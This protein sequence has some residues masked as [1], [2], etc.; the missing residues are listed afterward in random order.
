MTTQRAPRVSL[1]VLFRAVLFRAVLFRAVLFRAV[2][3]RAVLFLAVP[4]LA[5]P[6]PVSAQNVYVLIAPEFAF[7]TLRYSSPWQ[8]LLDHD[9]PL[10]YGGGADLGLHFQSRRSMLA[11]RLFTGLHYTVT[12][13][14]AA[15]TADLPYGEGYIVNTSFDESY[16]TITIPLRAE[17]LVQAR[18]SKVIPGF[19]V[20][21]L[22]NV[23]AS[24]RETASLV[25]GSR[26]END[27]PVRSPSFAV[28]TGAY[29]DLYVNRYV[30]LDF[31]AGY[32]AG[33]QDMLS[34]KDASMRL[35]GVVI[36]AG[37]AIRIR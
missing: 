3:F 37:V 34:D 31:R 10:S 23:S 14:S 32:A 13:V 26:S 18:N 25:D 12:K 30:A 7:N 8:G 36:G 15:V 29:L 27:I 9:R 35:N 5:T 22:V 1:T 17:I 16:Q 11:F 4:F 6:L 24:A 33:L 2:L 21:V 20:G 28:T 19:F